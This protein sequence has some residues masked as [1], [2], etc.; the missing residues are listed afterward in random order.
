MEL[1]RNMYGKLIKNNA[2]IFSDSVTELKNNIFDAK[3]DMEE[4]NQLGFY[5]KHNINEILLSLSQYFHA[6]NLIDLMK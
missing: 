3:I 4:S 6:A 2:S 5:I 1:P